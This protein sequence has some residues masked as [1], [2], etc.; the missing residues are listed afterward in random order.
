MYSRMDFYLL[1]EQYSSYMMGRNYS[2]NFYADTYWYNA[3]DFPTPVINFPTKFRATPSNV[4]ANAFT[5]Q[6]L[7]NG[8][9]LYILTTNQRTLKSNSILYD[10]NANY[11]F[12][13]N[14]DKTI[15]CEYGSNSYLTYDADLGTGKARTYSVSE[16]TYGFPPFLV[17]DK[18]FYIKNREYDTSNISYLTDNSTYIS[19]TGDYLLSNGKQF[20]LASEIP[21]STNGSTFYIKIRPYANSPLGSNIF[22]RVGSYSMFMQK[23]GSQIGV[24]GFTS[25]DTY[26]LYIGSNYADLTMSTMSN[27]EI[28]FTTSRNASSS[29]LSGTLNGTPI[30]FPNNI[31]I[32]NIADSNTT[33]YIGGTGNVFC[34]MFSFSIQENSYTF[35]TYLTDNSSYINYTG[36]YLLSNGNQFEIASEI[37]IAEQGTDF[38]MKIK[39]YP[40]SPIGSNIFSRVGSYSMSLQKTAFETY[41]L[42]IGSNYTNLNINSYSIAE[43]YFSVSGSVEGSILSGT[44]NGTPIVFPNNILISNIAD[45]NTTTYIGSTDSIFNLYTFSISNKIIVNFPYQTDNF[46]YIDYTGVYETR[47]SDLQTAVAI[48]FSP[49]GFTFY[50]KF[51]AYADAPIGAVVFCRHGPYYGYVPPNYVLKLTKTDVHTYRLTIRQNYN[52]NTSFVDLTIAD[53]VE[54]ELYFWAYGNEPNSTLGGRLDGQPIDF[55]NDMG[56]PNNTLVSDS[57]YTD[58]VTTYLNA[59][60]NDDD[61]SITNGN[62]SGVIYRFYTS[63]FYNP[64]V[65]P[66]VFIDALWGPFDL[67]NT[68]TQYTITSNLYYK[69]NIPSDYSS[70]SFLKN[71]NGI[72]FLI[73]FTVP[74]DPNYTGI[75][76]E[77]YSDNT[78]ISYTKND[79]QEVVNGQTYDMLFTLYSPVPDVIINDMTIL[80]GTYPTIR[81]FEILPFSL[82]T[83]SYWTVNS[84]SFKA[85][86]RLYDEW[87]F[88]GPDYTYR[89]KTIT[90][91]LIEPV[92]GEYIDLDMKR[93]VSFNT[94]N[95]N[96]I[97]DTKSLYHFYGTKDAIVYTK[98]AENFSQQRLV[99]REILPSSNTG[100]GLWSTY[101]KTGTFISS[102]ILDNS[103][104]NSNVGIPPDFL[105]EKSD[106]ITIRGYIR[107]SNS[108][109]V[110]I[111]YGGACSVNVNGKVFTQSGTYDGINQDTIQYFASFKQVDNSPGPLPIV[112][113]PTYH[114]SNVLYFGGVD[115]FPTSYIPKDFT[116][117][118]I[119][120]I[121]SQAN[122]PVTTL[123]RQDQTYP[124]LTVQTDVYTPYSNTSGTVPSRNDLFIVFPGDYPGDPYG[125]ITFTFFIMGPR[126]IVIPLNDTTVTWLDENSNIVSSNS[127]TTINGN[128]LYPVSV[129]SGPNTNL[130]EMGSDLY[131]P[132]SYDLS[133]TDFQKVKYTLITDDGEITSVANT[134]IFS[135][136]S[137]YVSGYSNVNCIRLLGFTTSSNCTLTSFNPSTLTVNYIDVGYSG[138]GQSNFIDFNNGS[139]LYFYQVLLNY[140]SDDQFSITGLD[141][142]SIIPNSVHYVNA[143]VNP[144]ETTTNVYTDQLVFGN[145]TT[146]TGN[147]FV[148]DN[149]ETFSIVTDASESSI[150]LNGSAFS[151]GSTLTDFNNRTYVGTVITMNNASQFS[152]DTIIFGPPSVTLSSIIDYPTFIESG[153]DIM[154]F[155]SGK[156]ENQNNLPL[157]FQYYGNAKTNIISTQTTYDIVTLVLDSLQ[158]YFTL[159]L[160]GSNITSYT[161]GDEIL[162]P[163]FYDSNSVVGNYKTSKL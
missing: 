125:L 39:T 126:N 139:N 61:G 28:Y 14:D 132:D 67:V 51:K 65:V 25:F 133:F 101:D 75:L 29:I 160:S 130:Y 92:Y 71:E 89:G 19:Y 66:N 45:S 122:N 68:N 128:G 157:D 56:F 72:S 114:F 76:F 30:V 162:I 156:F 46:T 97:S 8:E 47:G 123:H 32:S 58:S 161:D 50:I 118:R 26:R 10:S 13:F 86:D 85:Y 136:V 79:I 106:T 115:F 87:S 112:Y 143:N 48:P 16:F 116:T 53:Y 7:T 163:N 11:N 20:Q 111:N 103:Q 138:D 33:T 104:D 137:P 4:F 142:Y 41:R 42:S 73:N 95:V 105:L 109:P 153:I 96:E 159:Q 84:N 150:L 12:Y 43:L 102:R 140:P 54:T 129:Q 18:A 60:I 144:V 121:P 34:R 83:N 147:I 124:Q 94:R 100:Y 155:Y 69:L 152:T 15:R 21:I 44:L 35:P 146:I 158:N 77:V 9:Y 74:Q 93:V 82:D 31:L 135:N 120:Y 81:K 107:H 49:L 55:L 2:D 110:I 149:T 3:I 24:D 1:E 113:D 27:S 23:T 108:F 141:S 127:S 90:N 151:S 98:D 22:S 145:T 119:E 64:N 148:F 62:F 52:Y 88:F 5:I 154:N 40:D 91:E 59:D 78:Y 63:S 70:D 17:S 131:A 99:L 37:P 36:Y 6:D 117:N 57:V 134:D 80:N 38:F